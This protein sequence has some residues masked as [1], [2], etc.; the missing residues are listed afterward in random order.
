MRPLVDA[1]PQKFL[2]LRTESGS[3][4][5]EKL[6]HGLTRMLFLGEHFI[7]NNFQET[8]KAMI[9]PRRSR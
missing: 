5:H 9:R 8:L 2:D 4:V 3:I 6:R 1:D 7:F